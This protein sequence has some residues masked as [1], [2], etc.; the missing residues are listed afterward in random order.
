MEGKKPNLL[1]LKLE[2]LWCQRHMQ[3]VPL[4]MGLKVSMELLAELIGNEQ[5]IADCMG[6]TNNIGTVLD[7]KGPACCIVG[8][9]AVKGIYDRCKQDTK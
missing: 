4:P 1:D 3:D 7:Q 9:E 6:N 2:N 5:F 8:D